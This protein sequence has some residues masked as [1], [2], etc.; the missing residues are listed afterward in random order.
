MVKIIDT[1]G[2][3]GYD[4][5]MVEP[6]A[7]SYYVD[8]EDLFST[9]DTKWAED[10]TSNMDAYKKVALVRACINLLAHFSTQKGFRTILE[11]EN[12]EIKKYIDKTNERVNMDHALY[13]AIIRREIDGRSAFEIVNDTG[14]K[15]VMSLL[16]LVGSQVRPIINPKTFEI[17]KFKYIG[18]EKGEYSPEDI[19]Y[20]TLNA[21]TTKQLGNSAIDAIK[22]VLKL[23]RN[24]EKDLL[25]ASKRLWAPVGLFKLDTTMIMGADKK[26]AAV[27]NFKKEIKPGQSIVHN[28]AVEAKIIDLKPDINGL[29]RAIEKADEEIMGNWGIPK[30]LLAREKTL[31]KS[32]LEFSLKALWEGP[33]ASIQR[34]FRR[35]LERQWYPQLLEMKQKGLSE[36]YKVK[37]IFNP[38]AV[39][40]PQLVLSLAK[41]V[42]A[43]VIARDDFFRIIGWEPDMMEQPLPPKEPPLVPPAPGAPHEG[44]E[45]GE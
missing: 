15:N 29:V 7:L 34:Y 18:T 31:T 20:F 44:P 21:L 25:E 43:G 42:E 1:R 6:V 22:V 5:H 16:P 45:G 23:K 37:H 28:Q 38:I 17:E 9:A 27:S 3:S 41:A 35:E 24:L 14:K 4:S 12:E 8:V 30:A 33:V 13:L 10:L 11:P 26:R 40:D 36:Q 2:L 39:F 32:T 19:L